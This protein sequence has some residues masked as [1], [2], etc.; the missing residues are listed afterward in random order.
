MGI[1]PTTP[2]STGQCSNQLSYG[3]RES[4]A[5]A[6]ATPPRR[7][8]SANL[9]GAP[10]AGLAFHLPR[11]G[12][13]VHHDGL[14]RHPRRR[15]G[16]EEE[17]RIGDLVDL[18][19]APHADARRDGVVGLLAVGARLLE[20]LEIP[21]G[22][23]GARGDA[24]DADALAAPGRAEL[25]R[26]H[27]DGGLGR[28]VVGHHGRAVDAGDRGDVDDDAA[29]LGHHLLAGP[30]AAE[31]DAVQVDAD[32]GVPAVDGNILGLRPEGRAGV[33][34]HDVEPAPVLDGLLDH[35]LHLLLLA[36]INGH[37]E[38]APAQVAHGLGDG[39]EVLELAR[40][41]GDVGARARELDRDGL[42]DAGAAAGD[43][44]GLAVEGERGLRHG[45][46]D[47]PGRRGCPRP[48]RARTAT[49]AR[50]LLRQ[51]DLALALRHS[52][53]DAPPDGARLEAR[54]V[55]VGTGVELGDEPLRLVQAPARGLGLA[56][57]VL[58]AGAL[59]LLP[60]L[61]EVG[62]Q[63]HDALDAPVEVG[64]PRLAAR[65]VR[66]RCGQ[67]GLEL[68]GDVGGGA[69]VMLDARADL[70]RRLV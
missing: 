66:A 20:H 11:R 25:A 21:L 54:A 56:A 27:D 41:Q 10:A 44:R 60:G 45:G 68:A 23:D 70:L 36:D 62:D 33:V 69:Q 51:G 40:A 9:T 2:G 35:G 67:D 28:A 17:A 49:G 61:V 37:R 52:A 4:P 42:A 50:T 22:L 12:P 16:G 39:L 15:L 32:H 43:D 30:L 55:A 5:T 19:P 8:A 24:V 26:E 7:D 65:E 18:A 47:T 64:V 13:A 34:H 59:R 63:R 1:E 58:V 31:E 48:G 53:L 38:G 14:P 29:A 3:H 57:H 46:D 6:T